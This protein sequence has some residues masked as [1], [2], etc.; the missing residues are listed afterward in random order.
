MLFES[1][2]P[3][4]NILQKAGSLLGYKHTLE[5]LGKISEALKGK[6]HSVE[7]LEKMSEAKTGK[8]NP[9][10]GRTHSAET[11][12]KI[13]EANSGENNPMYGKTKEDHP[14]GMK[15]K[16]HST[17]TLAKMSAA[18][19]RGTIYVYNLDKTTLVNSFPS[20]RKAA[21]YFNSNHNTINKYTSNG[22]I[23]KEQWILSTSLITP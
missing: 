8:N 22:K 6:T 19:G 16:T 4:Y 23:F 17:D 9:M 14:C 7:T 2:V 18:K 12:A 3:R 11:I 15:G 13:S 20:A 21:K 10:F 5:A 1:K